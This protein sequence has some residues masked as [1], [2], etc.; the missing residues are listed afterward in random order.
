MCNWEE[1]TFQITVSGGYKRHTADVAYLKS[2]YLAAFAK[3]GYRWIFT[4]ST[5]II[6]EQIRNP[7]KILLEGAR[8]Y[9]K[10]S[11]STE[12]TFYLAEKPFPY[13]FALMG[14]TGVFLPWL[15]G[16][17][18]EL[19]SWLEK[20][21]NKTNSLKCTFKDKWPWPKRMELMLDQM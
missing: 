17:A 18:G 20:R 11:K 14:E 19:Y 1:T 7:G 16:D 2:A 9:V 15:E 5:E 13:L 10:A 3:F 4:P 8:I 12:F 21:R 6:R